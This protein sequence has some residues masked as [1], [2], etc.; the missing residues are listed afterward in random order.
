[1]PAVSKCVHVTVRWD[2]R[3]CLLDITADIKAAFFVN[4]GGWGMRY[5]VKISLGCESSRPQSTTVEMSRAMSVCC[6]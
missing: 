3:S 5:L 4:S 6:Q 1:M 2:V